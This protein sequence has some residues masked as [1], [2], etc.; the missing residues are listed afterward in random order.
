[1]SFFLFFSLKCKIVDVDNMRQRAT[2]KLIPRIDLHALA[3]KLL[4]IC[5]LYFAFHYCL[6]VVK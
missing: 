1:M 5:S 2:V 3:N 4:C 6:T